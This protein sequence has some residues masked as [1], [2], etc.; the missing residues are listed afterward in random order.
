[1]DKC[2]HGW[3]IQM[4][5]SECAP[6]Y[7]FPLTSGQRGADAPAF[8]PTAKLLQITCP[9]GCLGAAQGVLAFNGKS[10]MT[11]LLCQLSWSP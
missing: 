7:G 8:P 9:N 2:E 5:C 6:R 4:A 10:K 1:M 11:C 3:P